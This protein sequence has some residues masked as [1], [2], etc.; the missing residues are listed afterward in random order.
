MKKFSFKYTPDGSKSTTTVPAEMFVDSS[1]VEKYPRK[2][3]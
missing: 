3:K 1:I 2:V